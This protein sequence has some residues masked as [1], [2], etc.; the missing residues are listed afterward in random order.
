MADHYT[1]QV[2]DR[3]LLNQVNFQLP[4]GEVIAITGVN[5]SGK[6]TLLKQIA[7]R[8]PALVISPKAEI[9]FFQQMSYQFTAKE[10]V[11]SFVKHRSDYEEAFF[12]SVLH[13]MRFEGTDIYKDVRSLSGGEAIRLQLCLLFL[14]RYNILLLDEPTNFLD[15]DA[16]E[17]LE[18][19]IAGYQGTIIYV[20]HD[21]HFIERTADS[22]YRIENQQFVRED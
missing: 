7:E 14:G 12:R 6:S 16:I 5:G 8:D 13:S 1:L 9:G 22:I 4:L 20:S 17:A 2:A 3:V 10:Q 15:I 18:K 11:L 21:Q 19:F